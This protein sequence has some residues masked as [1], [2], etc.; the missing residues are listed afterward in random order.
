VTRPVA[1]SLFSNSLDSGTTVALSA[2]VDNGAFT[3]RSVPP[4]SYI[5]SAGLAGLSGEP[6]SVELPLI[7]GTEDITD[8]ALVTTPGVSLTGTVVFEDGARPKTQ[9]MVV[10]ASSAGSRRRNAGGSGA[11]LDGAF[12]IPN[13]IGSYRLNVQRLP[14]GW[15]VKS[16]EVDGVDVTDAPFAVTSGRPRAVVVL[17]NRMTDLSGTVTRDGKPFDADVLIF[18]DDPAK[19][20]AWRF[21]RSIRA[22]QQ[23][24]FSLKGLPPHDTYLALATTYL[25][26]DDVLSADFLALARQRATVFSLGEGQAQRVRLKVVDRSELDGP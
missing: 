25:E 8:L 5:V 11:V 9:G 1:V 26:P 19:W 21:V 3:V 12:R 24:Q 13:L 6:E 7:V 20:T 4:G 15:S 17:T 18:P 2:P 22:N 16:I 23:G 14:A 10:A